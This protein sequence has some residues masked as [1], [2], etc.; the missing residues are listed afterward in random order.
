MGPHS[1]P[2]SPNK[3]PASDWNKHKH[4]TKAGARSL[5]LG[6]SPVSTKEALR[7][8]LAVAPVSFGCLREAFLE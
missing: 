2:C 3:S 7:D 6:G 8:S 1:P 4:T 5:T